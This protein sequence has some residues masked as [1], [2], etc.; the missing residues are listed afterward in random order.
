MCACVLSCVQLFET[1]WTTAHQAPLSMGFSRQEH[2]SGMLYPLPGELPNPEIE[3]MSLMSSPLA[4]RF[5]TVM[6]PAKPLF[7]YIE[8]N[9]H[10]H[11]FFGMPK[12][13]PTIKA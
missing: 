13:F 4:G 9:V 8:C 3:P 5:F 1:L 10:A 7:L 12:P 6:P 11:I 2:W